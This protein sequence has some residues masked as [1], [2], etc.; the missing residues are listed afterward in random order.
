MKLLTLN[1]H[2]LVEE[3]YEEKLDAFVKAIAHIQPDIIALQEVNQSICAPLAEKDLLKNFFAHEYD[4]AVKADN[5]ALRVV[6]ILKNFG[7]DYFW[8]YIPIKLGYAKYEEGMA[9]L[10]KAEILQSSA[11][12]V[13]RN[14]DFFDWKTRKILGICTAQNSEE[15]F[16]CVHYGWWDDKDEPFYNQWKRTLEAL[17]ENKKIWLMGDFNNCAD[18]S[19]EGYDMICSDNWF[20]SYVCAK[21]KDDG[22]TAKSNIDGWGKSDVKG[23]RID[24][25]WH[26]KRTEI[27]DCRVV[28]NGTKFPVV[29]D[30]YGVLVE[31]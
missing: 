21:H 13:S 25:I 9:I 20:D 16:F 18:I 28:F 5:H 4:V 22:I 7:L 26:N 11:F 27:S 15:W 29:S 19:G 10:S 23:I 3:N 14:D 1:T 8:T 24:Q 12:C 30:H 6:N 2:S 31:Y 17:P